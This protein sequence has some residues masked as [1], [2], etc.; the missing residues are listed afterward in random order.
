MRRQIACVCVVLLLGTASSLTGCATVNCDAE[1][2]E[3]AP[4]DDSAAFADA[5]TKCEQR[6]DDARRKLKK[7]DEQR[8]DQER[9]DA[10]RHRN[11]GR[12]K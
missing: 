10:F 2:R 11:E 7:Q 5:K 1:A 3:A 12:P 6:I 4:P 8:E 9:R